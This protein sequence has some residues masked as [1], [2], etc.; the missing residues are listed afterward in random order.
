MLGSSL[1]TNTIIMDKILYIC[2]YH[3]IAIISV[4]TGISRIKFTWNA[5]QPKA[6]VKNNNEAQ[7]LGI[8]DRNY[9]NVFLNQ[10]EWKLTNNISTYR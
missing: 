9:L 10:G 5:I 6:P 7:V 1:C 2:D 4:N 8:N 3:I